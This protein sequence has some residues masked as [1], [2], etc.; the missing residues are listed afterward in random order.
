[1]AHHVG[2]S[3][4]AADNFLNK[5]CMQRRF[6]NDNLMKGAESLLE[7]RFPTDAE[8]FDGIRIESVPNVR[9]RIH[10]KNIVSESPDPFSPE[11]ML[12]TNGRMTVSITDCGTGVSLYDGIDI[13]VNSNDSFNRPQ[14]VFGVVHRAAV[15]RG[16]GGLFV[17]V[18]RRRLCLAVERQ[19]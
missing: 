16:R 14:G 10:G 11:T 8:T 12:L 6:M 18:Q 17:V 15:G 5:S 13:T 2:M 7:E 4:V 9:E 1:M 3:M 19:Y